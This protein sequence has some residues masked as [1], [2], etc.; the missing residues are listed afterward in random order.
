MPELT[1]ISWRDIPAQINGKG[2]ERGV[3]P[4]ADRFQKAI[5]RAAMGAGQIGTEE[6]VAR[7]A[8]HQPARAATTSPPRSAAAAEQIEQDFTNE[9]LDAAR[10]ARAEKRSRHDRHRHLARATKEVVI[11]FDR[12]FV[13]IGERINPT[14]RKL[15]AE[16]MKN[17]DFR[18]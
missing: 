6:Y 8:P 5:D 3:R 18:R 14:G 13:M 12:P 17:G 1:V 10:R 4:A 11:G 16:E 7:V 15:L 2:R 9:T